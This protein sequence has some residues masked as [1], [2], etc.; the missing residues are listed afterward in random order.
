M[1]ITTSKASSFFF[2]N[3]SFENDVIHI[4]KYGVEKLKN[5]LPVAVDITM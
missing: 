1:S 3:E 5:D 2:V 4:S